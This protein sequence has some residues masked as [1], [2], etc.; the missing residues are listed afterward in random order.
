MEPL[1]E[2]LALAY[3]KSL[4]GNRK[5]ERNTKAIMARLNGDDTGMPEHEIR[6]VIESGAE[7][8]TAQGMKPSKVKV[9]STD[10]DAGK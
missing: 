7:F 4:K 3:W 8:A 2:R 10:R 5:A 9:G 1:M 6:N